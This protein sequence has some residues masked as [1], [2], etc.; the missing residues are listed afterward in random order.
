MQQ[1]KWRRRVGW[2]AGLA[3]GLRRHASKVPLNQGLQKGAEEGRSV[4]EAR[5]GH[6]PR[7]HSLEN[8][9]CAKFLGPE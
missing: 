5:E 8:P 2:G 3:G 7:L 9:Q 1:S 6:V 4:P